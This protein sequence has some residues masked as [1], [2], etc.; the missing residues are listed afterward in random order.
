L[1]N[2]G[3]AL[4]R[5]CHEP[6]GID[7]ESLKKP[8]FLLQSWMPG[9]NHESTVGYGSPLKLCAMKMRRRYGG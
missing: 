3:K 7:F 6:Q 9:N 5:E 2:G 8:D 4:R 1:K